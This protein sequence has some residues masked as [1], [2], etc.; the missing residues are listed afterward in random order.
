MSATLL[1]GI[2]RLWSPDGT[3]EDAHLIISGGRIAWVGRQSSVP[4]AE[5]RGRVDEEID[6]DGRLVTPGLIDAHTHPVYAGQRHAEIAARTAGRSY[7]DLPEGSGIAATVAATRAATP[8]A[9]SEATVQ[10]LQAWLRAGATT[11]EAKTGYLLTEAGEIATVELLAEC[12]ARDDT[13]DLSITFLAAHAVPDEFDDPDAYADAAASWSERAAAAG[14]DNVDVFCDVGYFTVAQARRILT[15]GARHGLVPRVHADELDRT[16]GAQLAAELGA[17]SADHLLHLRPHDAEALARAGVVA[18]LCPGTALAMGSTPDVDA[19]RAA[20]TAIALG[21]DHNP[22]MF[23][24]TD[25]TLVVA[26]A[27]AALGMSVDEA[28]TA[29]T[30]GGAQALQLQDRGTIAPGKR[31]D[32]VCYDAGHEGAFAWAWGVPTHAVLCAGHRV[33]NPRR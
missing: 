6:V 13:P 1:S 24:S 11:V 12:R 31:A 5:L 10:R 8:D 14:A 29:A 18:V 4:P 33:T 22:G 9:L 2:G 3:V 15:T 23:G 17:A 20:G 21:S 7:R 25:M 26:L 28:L 30:V 27:V 19:L 32:L 16:G